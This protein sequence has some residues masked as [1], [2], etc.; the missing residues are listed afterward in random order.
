MSRIVIFVLRRVLI[1]I[2]SVSQML[3]LN[4]ASCINHSMSL[5]FYFPRVKTRFPELDPVSFS[6]RKQFAA[7]TLTFLWI[8]GIVQCLTNFASQMSKLLTRLLSRHDIHPLLLTLA[9]L[10]PKYASFLEVVRNFFYKTN[11]SAV[12]VL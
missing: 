9:P 7:S 6:R 5:F 3:G 2:Y 4:F 8:R 11:S 10:S 1:T 12:R